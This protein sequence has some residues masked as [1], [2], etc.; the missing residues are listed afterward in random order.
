M[1]TPECIDLDLKQVDA[2]LK[3]A[4]AS[5]PADDYEIIKAMAVNRP[6]LIPVLKKS[7]SRMPC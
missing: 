7:T 2:L 6:L 5:L 4:M 1:K 3:R